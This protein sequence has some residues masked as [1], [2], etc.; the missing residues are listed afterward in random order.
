MKF[1]LFSLVPVALDVP[2]CATRVDGR[3]HFSDFPPAPFYFKKWHSDRRS[4]AFPPLNENV[5]QFSASALIFSFSACQRRKGEVGAKKYTAAIFL[6]KKLNL[7][8]RLAYDL[9]FHLLVLLSAAPC[10]VNPGPRLFVVLCLQRSRAARYAEKK[11]NKRSR[12]LPAVSRK[13]I[14]ELRKKGKCF[15]HVGGREAFV[16]GRGE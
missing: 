1:A 3:D 12:P 11:P 15:A 5:T 7:T 10:A 9:I 14:L 16:A 13:R 4:S 6:I 8:G 2:F